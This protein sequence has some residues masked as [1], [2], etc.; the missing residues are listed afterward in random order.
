MKYHMLYPFDQWVTADEIMGWASDAI[1]NA[2]LKNTPTAG[3]NGRSEVRLRRSPC[4]WGFLEDQIMAFGE[5]A[6]IAMLTCFSI[7]A[8]VAIVDLLIWIRGRD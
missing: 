7:V 3:T 6:L 2:L 5:I 8:G 4:A 1:S